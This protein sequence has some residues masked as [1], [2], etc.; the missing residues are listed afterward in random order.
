[1]QVVALTALGRH[2]DGSPLCRLML[3]RKPAEP[4]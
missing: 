2:R 1:V 3:A 4:H